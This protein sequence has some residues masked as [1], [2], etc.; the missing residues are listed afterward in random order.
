MQFYSEINEMAKNMDITQGVG[1]DV[2]V[3]LQGN[4]RLLI[5]LLT[6]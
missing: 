6:F 5:A 3:V 4:E 2:N 1:V